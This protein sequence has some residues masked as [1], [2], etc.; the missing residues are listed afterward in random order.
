MKNR[1][2]DAVL[3]QNRCILLQLY[4]LRVISRI[5]N[6]LLRSKAFNN[7]HFPA[8]FTWYITSFTSFT[9]RGTSGRAAATRLG[10]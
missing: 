3:Y 2:K 9:V 5:K 7:L 4:L 10:A 8:Y 6:A 1:N